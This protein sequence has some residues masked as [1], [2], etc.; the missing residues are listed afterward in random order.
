MRSFHWELETTTAPTPPSGDLP[1]VNDMLVPGQQALVAKRPASAKHLTSGRYSEVLAGWAAQC[2]LS[3]VRLANEAMSARL[4]TSKGQAL[5]DLV[6]SD[7][8]T[9]VDTSPQK[10]VGEVYLQRISTDST[11]L[12]SGLVKVGTRLHQSGSGA[13]SPPMQSADFVTIE[14]AYF[15]PASAGSS[16]IITV[17]IEATQAGTSA[18]RRAYAPTSLDIVDTLFDSRLQAILYYSAGG[19]DGMSDDRLKRIAKALSL[20]QYGPSLGALTAGALLVKGVSKAVSS[21]P[22]DGSSYVWI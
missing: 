15:N 13:I 1:I 6:A 11:A 12:A 8:N 20:G 19:S 4:T 9:I 14:P 2:Q 3:L 17:K 18:N 22:G 16:Q 21:E 10:A 7:F 5:V